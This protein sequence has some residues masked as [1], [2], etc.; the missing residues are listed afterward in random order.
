MTRMLHLMVLLIVGGYGLGSE[1][2]AQQS[3][4]VPPGLAGSDLAGEAAK[5][6]PG[7]RIALRIWREPDL[8]GDYRVGEDGY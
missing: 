3:G 5:I 2:F 8:S 1:G 6:R 7:D 4:P